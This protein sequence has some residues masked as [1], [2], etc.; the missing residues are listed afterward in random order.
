MS[1]AIRQPWLRSTMIAIESPTAVAR[2]GDRREPLVEPARVDPDLERPEALLAQPERGL[3]PLP[4]PAAASRTTRRPGCPS[5]APPNSVA[6]GSPATWPTM[7]H[8]AASSGQ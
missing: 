6:T 4:R 1:P 8:S 7:S 2:R 5:V 3:G